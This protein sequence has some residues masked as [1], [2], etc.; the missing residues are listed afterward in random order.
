MKVSRGA[1]K[2]AVVVGSGPNG[3]A[4]AITLAQAGW[5]VTVFEAEGTPGGGVRSAELTL[6][7]FVHDVCAAVFPLA[8]SPFFRALPL[9]EHGLEWIDP[10]FA[11]AHPFDDGT[12]GTLGRGSEAFRS[13]ADAWPKIEGTALGPIAWPRHPVASAR[14]AMTAVR[15]ATGVARTQFRDERVRAVFAGLAAHSA[16]PL[17]EPLTA[18]VGLVLGAV[19]CSTGWPLPRGGAQSVTN[20]LMAHLRSLGGEIVAGTRVRSLDELPRADATLF[21]LSPKPLLEIAGPAFPGAFRR[22]LARYRY[23]A[24]VFK[25]DWALDGPIPW[26]AT[27]CAW[28]GTV[29]LGGTLEEIA[30]GERAVAKGACP[31]RPFVILAQPSLFDPTRAPEGKHT[32]W[33]YCHVPNGSRVDMRERI[34]NQIERFAPGFRDRI[35]ARHVMGP[36]EIE[37][38]NAN[39]VGGDIAS[40]APDFRQFFLRPTRRLYSTPVRGLYICSA[41]TPPG[42]GVH[43]MC[44]YFAARRALGSVG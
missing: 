1:D 5:H 37:S 20:A 10:S 28:A 31:E 2:N 25:M 3:L 13:L 4:A 30:A 23:G 35:L 41:S 22:K 11:L 33:A 18:G 8:A 6:P 12:A 15:S 27:A 21:D 40:G 38:H 34:E 24:G 44:G 14:F 39:F 32:A 16:M 7:G 17:E 36:A 26:R 43:G 19:A 29:H 9:A 42:P